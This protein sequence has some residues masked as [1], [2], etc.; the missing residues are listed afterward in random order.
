MIC[1]PKLSPTRP[2][3]IPWRNPS[4]STCIRSWRFLCEFDGGQR[5]TSSWCF[6]QSSWWT[7]ISSF[8]LE[9]VACIW[10]FDGPLLTWSRN[11]SWGCTWPVPQK[12]QPGNAVLSGVGDDLRSFYKWFV[13]LI[14]KRKNEKKVKVIQPPWSDFFEFLQIKWWLTYD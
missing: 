14:L 10:P 6:S 7:D 3:P 5:E 2:R 9:S 4:R 1:R 8:H 13:R 12:R 11:R